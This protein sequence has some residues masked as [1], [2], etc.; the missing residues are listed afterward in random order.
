MNANEIKDVIMKEYYPKG[1]RI[2][3]TNY[4]GCALSECDIIM[5]SNSRLIYE[6]EV[7]CTYSDF[8]AD[9]RKTHKHRCLDYKNSGWIKS[10]NWNL[11]PQEFADRWGTIGIPNHFYYACE[12]D[13]IPVEE[14]P[15]YAGLIYIGKTDYGEQYIKVIK[16][17]PK[18]HSYK[19]SDVLVHS[20]C[21][22]LTARM[23]YG[24]SYMNFKKQNKD[25]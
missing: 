25:L 15:S 21:K 22:A 16:R 17:A 7:K 3:T 6:F 9:F 2:M 20:I 1:Y 5:V 4:T 12:E 10:D 14:V 23:I 13:L 19:A 11:D 24:C 18:I 8:K